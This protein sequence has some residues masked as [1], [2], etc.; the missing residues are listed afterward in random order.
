M[1]PSELADKL[2]RVVSDIDV[3]DAARDTQIAMRNHLIVEA[4]RAGGTYA[5]IARVVGITRAGVR[6]ICQ[7]HGQ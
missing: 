1:I 3:I 7:H 2:G 6:W 4:E 5:E